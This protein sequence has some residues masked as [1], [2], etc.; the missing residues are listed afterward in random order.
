MRRPSF[1]NIF[2]L[3]FIHHLFFIIFSFMLY[4]FFFLSI[5]SL[6]SSM[7]HFTGSLSRLYHHHQLQPNLT[8]PTSSTFIISSKIY[9]FTSKR[10]FHS[11]SKGFS[12]SLSSSSSALS[13]SNQPNSYPPPPKKKQNLGLKFLIALTLF[14]FHP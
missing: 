2:L 9:I 12:T 10:K 3:S 4:L 1:A 5:S 11:C 7:H 8:T 6:R 14:Q 13:L